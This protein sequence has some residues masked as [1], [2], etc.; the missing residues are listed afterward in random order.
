MSETRTRNVPKELK[1][2]FKEVA[3]K[4]G[5][6]QDE[7]ED[8]FYHQF[9]YLKEMIEKGT[10]NEYDTFENVLFK[11]LGTFVAN[12]KHV[13][14]LKEITDANKSKDSKDAV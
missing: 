9:K 14:K 6:T 4:V 5:V 1:V 7:A 10:Y 12:E 2:L 13:K 11:Y 8:I 3:E